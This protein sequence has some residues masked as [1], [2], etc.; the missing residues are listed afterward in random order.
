MEVP[1]LGVQLEL[2]P[3]DYATAIAMCDQSCVCNLHHSSQQCWVL[4]PLSKARDHTDILMDASW[5]AT[6]E[7][8]IFFLKISCLLLSTSILCKIIK[9]QIF[10]LRSSPNALQHIAMEFFILLKLWSTILVSSV[11]GLLPRAPKQI[12]LSQ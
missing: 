6:M 8:P 3:P 11:I 9:Y 4:N 2:Q 5:V 1:R 10:L 7:T 12:L